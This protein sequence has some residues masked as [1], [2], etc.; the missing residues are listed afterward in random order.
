MFTEADVEALVASGTAHMHVMAS[1]ETARFPVV[2]VLPQVGGSVV[3]Q[4]PDGERISCGNPRDVVETV[5]RFVGSRRRVAPPRPLHF[6]PR[7]LGGLHVFFLEDANQCLVVWRTREQGSV[8]I[9]TVT[10]TI[11]A[12]VTEGEIE[13]RDLSQ[14]Q[15]DWLTSLLPVADAWCDDLTR[16]GLNDNTGGRAAAP[17]RQRIQ[18]PVRTSGG[19]R[20]REVR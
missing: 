19:K 9:V 10:A 18:V 20:L 16:R 6:R 11:W 5:S 7:H 14:R 12:A 2:K 13:D 3:V 15:R 4:T 1:C 17:S 8:E